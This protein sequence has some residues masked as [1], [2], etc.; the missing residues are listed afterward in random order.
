MQVRRRR[1]EV[2]LGTWGNTTLFWG[3]ATCIHGI[4]PSAT[5]LPTQSQGADNK[6]VGLTSPA[7]SDPLPAA[8]PLQGWSKPNSK[9]NGLQA[10]V[11]KLNHP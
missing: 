6:A 8:P 10:R 1:P 2:L 4:S 11:E 7:S 5:R 9:L 3:L